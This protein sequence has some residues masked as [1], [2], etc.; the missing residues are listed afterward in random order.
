M[1][2]PLLALMAL[3]P[4]LGLSASAHAAH[5]ACEQG[6]PTVFSCHAAKGK[7]VATLKCVG[8]KHIVQNI[9]GIDLGPME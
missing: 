3:A 5:A 1:T 7:L 6:T 4:A 2:R 8:E 9:E